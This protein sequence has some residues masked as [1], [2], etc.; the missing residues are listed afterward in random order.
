[1]TSAE[2]QYSVG[3]S[4]NLQIEFVAP[5]TANATTFRVVAKVSLVEVAW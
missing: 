3:G 5:T 4:N 1:M 2:C